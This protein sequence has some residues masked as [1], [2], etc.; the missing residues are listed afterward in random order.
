MTV[1]G[2]RDVKY[3]TDCELRQRTW[4]RAVVLA[5][6]AFLSFVLVRQTFAQ[7]TAPPRCLPGA[8]PN[9]FATDTD[10]AG[11]TLAVL[12]CD[13]AQGIGVSVL[14]G[15]LS[16]PTGA[17]LAATQSL[18]ATVAS[19]G[20]WW[21]GCVTSTPT[22]AQQTAAHAF[23]AQ[24]V[25]RLVTTGGN[26]VNADKKIV[27]TTAAGVP[28]GYAR[29]PPGTQRWYALNTNKYAACAITFPGPNGFASPDGA[30]VPTY[31]HLV[32]SAGSVWTVTGGVVYVQSIGAASPATA[33]FSQNVVT[34]LYYGGAIYQSN[35]A[36]G[37]WE[38]SGAAWVG[39]KGDPRT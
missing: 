17:C 9:N 38:W 20:A 32:D 23:A 19:V 22:A 29:L 18:R 21:Q 31:L 2:V 16:T 13:D 28:C 27:G 30:A 10:A 14:G 8:S 26:V 12:W 11:D 3:P 4:F 33:G 34:L 39:V 25:P 37:W 5:L 36:G 24:W 15:A 1:R 7:S 35:A 6:L